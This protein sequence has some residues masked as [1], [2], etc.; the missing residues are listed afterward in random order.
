MAKSVVCPGCSRVVAIDESRCHG[1]GWRQPGLWGWAPALA[2]LGERLPFP[3]IVLWG[4]GALFVTTLLWAPETI[5]RVFDDIGEGRVLELLAPAYQPL[6]LFGMSGQAPVFQD[7]RWW[8]V[9]S[10]AWLHGSLL[11]ILFNMMWIRHLAPAVGRRF[12]LARLVILYTVSSISGFLLTS[13]AA[14]LPGPLSGA[15]YTVGASAPLFGLFGALVLYGQRSGNLKM[16]RDFLQYVVIWV[17]IGVVA[18]SGGENAIRI[19]NW[20]HLGGFAGGYL[21]A[22]WLDPERKEHP[23]HVLAALLCLLATALSVAASIVHGLWSM[24]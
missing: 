24:G 12:G 1:C 15:R 17:V 9:L 21:A 2:R 19:D 10:A 11:H 7:G 5:L 3:A 20:A 16:S 18:S 4:C 8:T 6:F 23:R 13:L 22:R 14:F